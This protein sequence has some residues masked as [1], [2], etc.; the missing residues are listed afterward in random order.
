MQ[1]GLHRNLRSLAWF[2]GVDMASFFPRMYNLAV[3]GD[4]QVRPQ[5]LPS[6]HPL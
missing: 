3:P 5:P 1:V 4:M 2:D 6:P